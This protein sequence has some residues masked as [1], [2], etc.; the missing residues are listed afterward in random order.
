MSDLS[1]NLFNALFQFHPRDGH[2]PKENFLSEGF[3]YV[4]TICDEA[5]DE[6]LSLALGRRV[7]TKQFEVTTRQTERDENSVA[8]FPDMRVTGVFSD[9]EAFDLYSEHKW[10][11]RCDINQIK[12]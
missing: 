9:G 12:K 10:D 2:S 11:S 4:L 3:A 7:R 5:R 6:W 8:V 1:P